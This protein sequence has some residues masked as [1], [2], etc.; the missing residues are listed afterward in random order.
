MGVKEGLRETA[1]A[2]GKIEDISRGQVVVNNKIEVGTLRSLIPVVVL[3][4]LG[5]SRNRR[6]EVLPVSLIKSLTVTGT[7]GHL[8]SRLGLVN[9]TTKVVASTSVRVVN[10]EAFD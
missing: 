6:R 1:D 2:G 7:K 8:G 3:L 9:E 5:S 4:P 10:A